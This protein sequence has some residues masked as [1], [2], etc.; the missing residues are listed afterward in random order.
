[1]P[2]ANY[3]QWMPNAIAHWH[4]IARGTTFSVGCCLEIYST[5]SLLLGFQYATEVLRHW[6]AQAMGLHIKKALATPR[7]GTHLPADLPVDL[8]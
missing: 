2:Q 6:V 7:H 3:D 4:A 1:M 5:V 8:V